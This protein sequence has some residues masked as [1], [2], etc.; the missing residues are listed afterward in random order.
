[1]DWRDRTIGIVVGA[2]LGVGIVIA[3]VFVLSDQTVDA[4]SLSGVS[5]TS[6]PAQRKPG[7][8]PP[9]SEPTPKPTPPSAT[10]RVIGGAPPPSG[11]AEL[12]YRRG[13]NIGLRVIS[14][15]DLEL[16][17]TGYGV[18]WTVGPSH[19]GSMFNFRASRTGTFAVIVAG[20]H[21][22]VARITVDGRSN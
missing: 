5:T 17:V 16:R 22:D 11:P 14:D 8:S 20:S 4:P 21:I 3:F 9:K 15:S 13:E 10:V 6:A 19:A 12:H 1:V 2:V 18:R 7:G